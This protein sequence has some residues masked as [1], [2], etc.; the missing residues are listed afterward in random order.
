MPNACATPNASPSSEFFWTE[1][2]TH[3]YTSG[4]T[5]KSTV[6]CI[7]HIKV[8]QIRMTSL[9]SPPFVNVPGIANF[10]DI[11]GNNVRRGLVYRSADPSKPTEEGLMKMKDLGKVCPTMLALLCWLS[12]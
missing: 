8:T 3:D 7:H 1:G 6:P 11:G 9:P 5:V 10:R 12:H 2:D 4:S